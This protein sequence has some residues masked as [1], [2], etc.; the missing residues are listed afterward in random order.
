MSSTEKKPRLVSVNSIL[1]DNELI[2]RFRRAYI[3]RV[4][5]EEKVRVE[6]QIVFEINND[7][8]KFQQSD[9]LAHITL[10][11][12]EQ[13]K[14]V[15]W[16][17]QATD[18]RL[19]DKI[20]MTSSKYEYTDYLLCHDDDIHGTIEGRRIAFIY[21]LVS[22]DWQ[23]TDGGTLDLFE[24]DNDNQPCRI[25]TSLV[26][27]RNRLTFFEVTD[28]SYHQVAEV[29]NEKQ[30]ARLSINGWF[31]GPVNFRPAPVFESLPTTIPATKFQTNDLDRVNQTITPMYL[32]VETQYDVQMAFQEN[33]ET[34]LSD[35]FQKDFFQAMVNE[36]KSDTIKWI[37]RGPYNKRNY[38]IAD[39][40]SLPSALKNLV[41]LFG[42]EPMFTILG[43]LTGLT[44]ENDED[45][46]TESYEPSPKKRKST[47]TAEVTSTSTACSSSSRWY[48]ELRRWKHTYYSLSYDT[49]NHTNNDDDDDEDDENEEEDKDGTLDVMIFFNYQSDGSEET[50]GG[51]D[52]VYTIKNEDETL[53]RVIPDDNSLNLIYREDNKVLNYFTEDEDDHHT[54]SSSLKRLITISSDD[55]DKEFNQQNVKRQRSSSLPKTKPLQIMNKQPVIRNT[56]QTSLSIIRTNSNES[57]NNESKWNLK[58]ITTSST[59]DQSSNKQL[60]K[61]TTQTKL[62]SFFNSKSSRPL[63][64]TVSSPAIHQ[65][66]LVNNV[67]RTVSLDG[68][69][70]DANEIF[71][72]WSDE[73]TNTSTIDQTSTQT[74]T[75]I[76]S[77]SIWKQIFNKPV[78]S[79][80]DDNELKEQ[81]SELDKNQS[82]NH[83][84]RYYGSTSETKRTCPFYK[85]I[86]GTTFCVDAFNFGNIDG[87]Q[88]Y[89]LSHF[90]SDHYGGL[91]KKF[92]NMLYS[93]Q[94]TC[95]LCKSQ[96]GVRPEN[97]TIL[98]MDT[99]TNVHGID[100]ALIDAN[101]CPGSNMFLFRFPNGKL[102][103]HTGDFRAASH[104]M[105]HPLLQPNQIDTVY[106]DTTYCDSHYRFPSQ[107]EVIESAVELVLEQLQENPRILIAIGAYLVGKERVFHA[108][109]KALDCKIFVEARKF[110]ILNQLDNDD[111]SKR[112]TTKPN[113]TNVHVVGMG[114]VTSPMLQTHMDKYSLNYTK[115]IGIKPTGWTTPRATGG[116]KHYSIESKSSNIT[117][118]GFP[119]SEHSSFNELKTFIEYLKPKRIIPTV[120]VGRANVREKMN[121]Y[122]KQ[123]L[124]V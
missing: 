37:R 2:E 22:D 90:H 66:E 28:K 16:L 98:P 101:H 77:K 50:T 42:S 68:F 46:E 18:I 80:V 25:V 29:L 58:M 45:E 78:K 53:L 92:S 67:T 65:E 64:R 117:V 81:W 39:V 87:I 52:V 44:S 26:P 11:A 31:H 70:M 33:S 114:S 79:K 41:E 60:K 85:K 120:N 49:D 96:L 100:V 88:A 43:S 115:V 27:K 17:V 105:T 1:S 116:S 48:F 89:F 106:L 61:K 9:D 103:L 35:F 123:W 82:T 76:N 63:V 40:N 36:L 95:N 30:R 93:N 97:M 119:Y 83:Q 12:I 104:L 99:F 118:Y 86:P 113:E 6:K 91:N 111:L 32:K 107:D 84:H 109:A 62:S 124:S 74:K 55:E 3:N 54:S 15:Y 71:S 21:Y 69:D 72:Q 47:S 34:K 122:F 108:I 14:W 10:P 24:T 102:I 19:S 57:D 112:L 94:I 59:S 121:G 51:G 110:R 20:D 13:I 75:T 4:S 8:Y 56:R 5:I 7:L 73:V 23:E 38:D